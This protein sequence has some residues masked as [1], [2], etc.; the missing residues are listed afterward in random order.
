MSKE[1]S[2]ET[3]VSLSE[4]AE[5]ISQHAKGTKAFNDWTLFNDDEN[6][7]LSILA[8]S[9]YIFTAVENKCLVGVAFIL[10]K[11]KPNEYHLSQLLTIER[12]HTKL[13]YLE[14][15]KRFPKG[16][17]KTATRRG[18]LVTFNN[19]ARFEQIIATFK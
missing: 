11:N 1:Q 12:K 14:F 2:T 17:L 6:L 4:I 9:G 10:P 3:V 16:C 5:F 7:C 19:T 13:L 18:R 8:A 15:K